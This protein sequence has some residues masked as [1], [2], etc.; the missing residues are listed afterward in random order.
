MPYK[1]PYQ[2]SCK[3]NVTKTQKKVGCSICAMYFHIECVGITEEQCRFLSQNKNVFS[4]ICNSCRSTPKEKHNGIAENPTGDIQQGLND[5]S[6][7]IGKQFEEHN[8]I[9]KKQVMASIT[10]LEKKIFQLFEQF[11]V[12][13]TERLN[14]IKNDN[15]KKLNQ[16]ENAF[17]K[18]VCDLEVRNSIL[19]R[20]LNRADIIIKGL[21]KSIRKLT[22][23]ILNIATQCGVSLSG[24]DIQHCTYI[25]NG[26]SVLVKLNSVQCRD[27]IMMNFAK[28]KFLILKDILGGNVSS[29]VFLR[30]HLT[31]AA[32]ELVSICRDL[33]I[34]NKI[35]SYK[36]INSDVP[37]VK[38]T[39]PNNTHKVLNLQQCTS[40]ISD[41]S[42]CL[43][44]EML[45]N[46][47][48]TPR[49]YSSPIGGENFLPLR[50]SFSPQD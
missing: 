28:K 36:F 20:R 16:V 17:N 25:H 35:I 22:E 18:R 44:E 6:T 14:K 47:A 12:E 40:M 23:P 37:K 30:D 24:S 45:H 2:C 34:E 42:V 31:A 46:N 10:E 4:Y 13:Q 39:L 8:R 26:R 21:P 1:I 49:S 29:K 33:R 7:E 48:S 5:I 43:N 3:K 9:F 19:Q 50:R 15:N 27:A 41:E 11:R 32:S 38:V